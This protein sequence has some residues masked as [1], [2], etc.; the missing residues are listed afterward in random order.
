MCCDVPPLLQN[1]IFMQVN[2]YSPKKVRMPLAKW[3][4]GYEVFNIIT[5]DPLAP[6]GQAKISV[7]VLLTNHLQ[8]S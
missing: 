3:R 4:I 6:E 1:P 2:E 8:F 5:S 7:E